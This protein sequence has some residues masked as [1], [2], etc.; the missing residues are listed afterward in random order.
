[1]H[2][3]N[4]QKPYSNLSW[5]N[6]P[7]TEIVYYEEFLFNVFIEHFQILCHAIGT[8]LLLS[9]KDTNTSFWWIAI[10]ITPFGASPALAIWSKMTCA[11]LFLGS[12]LIGCLGSSVK[13]IVQP[14]TISIIF[15][16]AVIFCQAETKCFV[17][18]AMKV[19]LSLVALK[20]LGWDCKR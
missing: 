9:Y 1:M 12:V 14:C 3:A 4:R 18:P 11:A 17:L 8:I 15:L 16:S 6:W 2:P 10:A 5:P 20:V 13:S 19:L 7:Q